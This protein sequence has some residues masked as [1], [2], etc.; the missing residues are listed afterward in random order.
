MKTLP[1]ILCIEES[2]EQCKYREHDLNQ[3]NNIVIL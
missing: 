3:L 1:V 2:E